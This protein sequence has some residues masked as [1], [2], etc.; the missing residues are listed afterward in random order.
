MAQPSES[1]SADAT[2]AANRDVPFRGGHGAYSLITR[3]PTQNDISV[4]PLAVRRFLSSDP[5]NCSSGGTQ[6]DTCW[7]NG[8]VLGGT[9]PDALDDS[10]HPR[11]DTP[12]A[13]QSW[14]TY[15]V[16]FGSAQVWK[17]PNTFPTT[18]VRASPYLTQLL[19]D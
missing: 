15:P 7:F 2:A 4:Q 18:Y 6:T 8:T 5:W 1:F 17:V 14:A 16:E 10:T 19:S 12:G 3:A 9:D 13:N 11:S